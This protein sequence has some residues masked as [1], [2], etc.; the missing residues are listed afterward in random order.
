M[1]FEPDLFEPV[2]AG[3]NRIVTVT[4]QDLPHR[5]GVLGPDDEVDVVLALRAAARPHRVAA[6]QCERDGFPLQ[7]RRDGLEHLAL[8]LELG[9]ITEVPADSRGQTPCRP[10]TLFVVTHAALPWRTQGRSADA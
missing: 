5:V 8:F 3:L 7:R 4:N 2:L 1:P 9:H 10:R 6:G